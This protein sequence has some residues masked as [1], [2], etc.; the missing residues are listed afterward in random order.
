[1]SYSRSQRRRIYAL[2]AMTLTFTLTTGTTS[3]LASSAK[4]KITYSL[5]TDRTE[6]AP[7]HGDVD[8][9]STFTLAT[10]P[11]TNRGAGKTFLG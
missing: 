7:T 11:S 9:G 5:G 2:V 3:S 4:C 6:T 1:M 10:P 8:S